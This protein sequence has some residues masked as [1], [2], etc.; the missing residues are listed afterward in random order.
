MALAYLLGRDIE[1]KDFLVSY[2][3]KNYSVSQSEREQ[4]RM[5]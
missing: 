5:R 2:E 1:K 4:N 3:I